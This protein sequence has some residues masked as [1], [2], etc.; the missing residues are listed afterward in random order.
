MVYMHIYAN[1]WGI[2]MGSMLPY[3]AAPWIR[4][5]LLAEGRGDESNQDKFDA[6]QTRHSKIMVA[7]DN[8]AYVA[9]K[10][11]WTT[12]G[13][14][15]NIHI[16]HPDV[17][18][19]NPIV[20]CFFFGTVTIG[21]GHGKHVCHFHHIPSRTQLQVLHPNA[22]SSGMLPF[23]VGDFSSPRASKAS[24]TRITFDSF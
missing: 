2:L 14:W 13:G 21:F 4:H 12:A 1:I 7:D 16:N 10:N 23:R 18:K 11:S 22:G 15:L 8:I 6:S 19:Y 17:V 5:G 20:F 9:G 3:I 24:F